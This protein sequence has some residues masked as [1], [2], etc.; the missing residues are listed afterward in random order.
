MLDAAHPYLLRLL[1]PNCIGLIIPGIGFNASFAPGN[2]LPGKL[3]FVT[4]SGALAKA[5][6]ALASQSYSLGFKD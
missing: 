5:S 2:A 6:M 1:G 4:Q 3:A